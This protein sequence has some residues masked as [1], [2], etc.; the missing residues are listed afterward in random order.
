ELLPIAEGQYLPE[1]IDTGYAFI[2]FYTEQP[3]TPQDPHPVDADD[4]ALHNVAPK[5]GLPSHLYKFGNVECHVLATLSAS[6]GF[7]G[8]VHCFIQRQNIYRHPQ[9]FRTHLTTPSHTIN[10]RIALFSE[11]GRHTHS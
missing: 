9:K 5:L 3:T 7:F 1:E 8:D 2:R 10:S 4:V 6:H 11:I